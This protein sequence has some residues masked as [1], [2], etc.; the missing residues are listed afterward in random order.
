MLACAFH[1]IV[2]I[3]LK[4]V[5]FLL[6]QVAMLLDPILQ[7]PAITVLARAQVLLQE[8]SAELVRRECWQ[9]R[10]FFIFLVLLEEGNLTSYELKKLRTWTTAWIWLSGTRTR[11]RLDMQR[12]ATFSCP[13][14]CFELHGRCLNRRQLLLF[15]C[16]CFV[17]N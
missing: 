14:R 1:G 13:A 7:H 3:F 11:C 16:E 6:L 12:S 2:N 17:L 10:V 4:L 8:I 5:L 9:E 15:I